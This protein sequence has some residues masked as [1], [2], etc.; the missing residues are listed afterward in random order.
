MDTLKRYAKYALLPL[1]LVGFLALNTATAKA[2]VLYEQTDDS[3]EFQY[4]STDY[5]WENF[6][7]TALGTGTVKSWRIWT[8]CSA[9]STSTKPQLCGSGFCV[10]ADNAIA[11]TSTGSW[12]CY[13]YAA[14]VDL[15]TITRLYT[16][17]FTGC[18]GTVYTK[19]ESSPSDSKAGWT[20]TSGF[21]QTDYAQDMA[22]TLYSNEDC[23]EGTIEIDQVTTNAQSGTVQQGENLTVGV[24]AT[25]AAGVAIIDITVDGETRSCVYYGPAYP[26]TITCAKTFYGLTAGTYQ[27]TAE[28]T[29][30]NAETATDTATSVDVVGFS[31]NMVTGTVA[32]NAF[33]GG[34]RADWDDFF[35]SLPDGPTC[36]FYVGFWADESDE[37]GLAC[38]WSWLKY[39][40][41]PP[42]D[43]FFNV[44][45]MP[46][47]AISAAWP[48]V[49]IRDTVGNVLGGF[50][51]DADAVCPLPDLGGGTAMGSALPDWTICDW[52]E[53]AAAAVTGNSTA[54]DVFEALIYAAL[55]LGLYWAARRFWTH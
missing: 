39:L 49:Y 32:W 8:R 23:E 42:T 3:A 20:T 14:G 5:V 43:S 6:T 9:G 12:K 41:I 4:A 15:S 10:T 21:G 13:N 25:S 37:D 46:F 16:S 28:A 17:A 2:A 34:N 19:R 36:K 51:Y 47:E 29:A 55:A 1:L 18:S 26:T 38:L 7:G 11:I 52:V 35:A 40:I 31:E 50:E 22:V 24:K 48:F 33:S 27:I 44:L 30:T 54:V 53:D 45:A